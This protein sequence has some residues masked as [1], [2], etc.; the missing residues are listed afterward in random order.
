MSELFA[1]LPI[2]LFSDLLKTAKTPNDFFPVPPEKIFDNRNEV[3]PS[4]VSELLLEDD[5]VT[6]VKL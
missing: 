3:I 1:L 4:F 6:L 5:V 2:E